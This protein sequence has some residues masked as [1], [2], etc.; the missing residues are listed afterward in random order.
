MSDHTREELADA[1]EEKHDDEA[2]D[3]EASRPR[4][5][6]PT[7]L[8]ADTRQVLW[9]VPILVV[10]GTCAGLAFILAALLG[11]S[12]ALPQ[13]HGT[14]AMHALVGAS[15]TF[16]IARVRDVRRVTRRELEI[17]A[18]AVISVIIPRFPFHGLALGILLIGA[19]VGDTKER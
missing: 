16:V 11:F 10:A 4:M 9:H 7:L 6:P 15:F 14:I 3:A 12:N 18:L 2:E 8:G 5:A 1:V 13:P 19:L 17:A